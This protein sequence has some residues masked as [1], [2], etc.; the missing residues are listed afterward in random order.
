VAG[1]TITITNDDA[2]G[3]QTTIRVDTSTGGPVVT[4]LTVRAAHGGGLTPHQ[5]PAVDLEQLIGALVPSQQA[6]ITHRPAPRTA[7]VAQPTAEAPKTAGTRRGAGTSTRAKTGGRK[8][9]AKKATRSR[10]TRAEKSTAREA[11]NGRRA[12]RR[13]PEANEVAEAYRQAGSASGVA[14]HFDVP[15]HTAAGWIR[16]LRGQGV[17]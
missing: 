15:R 11:V 1:F 12:Y 5:L 14:E 13:M 6:A 3:A 7:A 9:P 8:A 4:E 16:R 17:L 10:L 2:S